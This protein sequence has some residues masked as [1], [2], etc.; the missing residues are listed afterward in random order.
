MIAVSSRSYIRIDGIEI[1]NNIR[2]F[3]SGIYITGSGTDVQV[4]NCNIYN[5][6]WTTDSTAVPS[7]SDNANPGGGGYSCDVL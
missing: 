1:A 3:A 6:G 2:S 4:V 5:I 7:S